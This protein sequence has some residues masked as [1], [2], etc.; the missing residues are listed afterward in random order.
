MRKNNITVICGGLLLSS[1]FLTVNAAQEC[2]NLI[3]KTTPTS[4]FK[5]H[6]DGTVTD[7]ETG[8]MWK[9]CIEG[10]LG[11]DCTTGNA[12]SFQWDKALQI[13]ETL[14]VSGG[15]AGHTN[16]RLP[17]IKELTS[18]VEYACWFPAINLS[19]FPNTTKNDVVWSGSPSNATNYSWSI[20]FYNGGIVH[21]YRAENRSVRLVRSVQ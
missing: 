19:V 14:N 13:G 5:I 12:T 7:T 2:N 17:N 16:W 18:I 4:Q 11:H 10:V 8:L 9:K 15:Y 21:T 1:F 3:T 6:G 20:L